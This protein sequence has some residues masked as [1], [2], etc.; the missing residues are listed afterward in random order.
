[1]CALF[2]RFFSP[3]VALWTGEA[4]ESPILCFALADQLAILVHRVVQFAKAD[5]FFCFSL[6]FFFP[7][8]PIS[9]PL[10]S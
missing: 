2:R 9:V 3:A 7:S 1:V 10:L 8:R 6:P 4:G 5:F